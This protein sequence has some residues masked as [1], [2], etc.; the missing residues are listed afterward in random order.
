M[1]IRPLLAVS[2][3]TLLLPACSSMD[4]KTASIGYDDGY[5][6]AYM[7][8]VEKQA[9]NNGT[10]VIWINPPQAKKDKTHDE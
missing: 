9:E 6:H 8:K 2:A 5:D 7:A 3:L 4:H 1:K 10:E